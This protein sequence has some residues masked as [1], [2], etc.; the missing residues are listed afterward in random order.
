MSSCFHIYVRKESVPPNQEILRVL[1]SRGFAMVW[2]DET[3][4]TELSGAVPFTIDGNTVPVH[5]ETLEGSE[6]QA[7]REDIHSTGMDL[8]VFNKLMKNVDMRITLSA[9]EG[10]SI[11]WSRDI[12]RGIALVSM[13]TFANAPNASRL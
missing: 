12:A 11:R 13:G 4:I 2:E 5:I 8:E 7:L 6:L 9:E 10:E 3:P 1:S